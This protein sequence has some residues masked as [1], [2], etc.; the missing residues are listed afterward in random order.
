M[1]CVYI[2]G[3]PSRFLPN[4]GRVGLKDEEFLRALGGLQEFSLFELIFGETAF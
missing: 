2:S 1:V 3:K 4:E